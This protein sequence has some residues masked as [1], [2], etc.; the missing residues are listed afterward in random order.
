MIHYLTPDNLNDYRAFLRIKQLP[1]RPR[2][3]GTRSRKPTRSTPA[4]PKARTT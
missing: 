2:G 1:R 4:R 3:R